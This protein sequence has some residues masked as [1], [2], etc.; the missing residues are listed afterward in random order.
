MTSRNVREHLC[1]FTFVTQVNNIGTSWRKR[2][3][4]WAVFKGQ[5]HGLEQTRLKWSLPADENQQM[6]F[7]SILKTF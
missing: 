5:I 2:D 6:G 7:Q 1:W 3:K 4:M